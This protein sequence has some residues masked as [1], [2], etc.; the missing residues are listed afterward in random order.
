MTILLSAR[1]EPLFDQIR[2]QIRREILAGNLKAG[3]PLPSLRQLAGDLEVSVITVKRAYDDLEKE[4]FVETHPGRGTLVSG[5]NPGFWEEKR[6]RL[7]E[8]GLAALLD[9]AR[10]LGMKKAEVQ[11]LVNLL[12]EES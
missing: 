9:Q 5:G 7:V 12:W 11:E 8:E 6:R 3:E 2:T 1:G 10:G 4:G